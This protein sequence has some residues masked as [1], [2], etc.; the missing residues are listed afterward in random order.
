MS[1]MSLFKRKVV[2]LE[3]EEHQY[4][5]QPK[6]TEMSQIIERFHNKYMINLNQEFKN[7]KIYLEPWIIDRDYS[8]LENH[9]GYEDG[10]TDVPIDRVKGV[11]SIRGY[12]TW[13]QIY[14]KY[15]ETRF[16]LDRKS[17]HSDIRLDKFDHL[18]NFIV[19]NGIEEYKKQIL[20]NPRSKDYPYFIYIQG[21]NTYFIGN[22]GTHRAIIA[23]WLGLDNIK[24]IEI[25]KYK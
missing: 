7:E 6:E 24:T 15:Y 2:T 23:K 4:K 16:E 10:L 19:D 1:I 13:Y 5:I 8:H 9:L 12:E 20:D 22:D 17:K 25:S 14:E 11:N 21:D 3:V 18:V